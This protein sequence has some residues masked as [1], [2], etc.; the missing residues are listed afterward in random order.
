MT[1]QVADQTTETITYKFMDGAVVRVL[2]SHQCG[3]GSIPA[4]CHTWVEFVAGSRLAPRV[5][6]LGSPNSTRTEAPPEN[7][8]E[9]M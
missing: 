5:F 1:N 4:W 6:F 2:A 8:L 3:L 9:Q 7:Q